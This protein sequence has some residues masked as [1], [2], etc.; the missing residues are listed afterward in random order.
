MIASILLAKDEYDYNFA[1]LVPPLAKLLDDPKTKIRFVATEALAVLAKRLG[2]EN[3]NDELQ[4]IVDGDALESLQKRFRFKAM[5]IIKDNYI[6]FPKTIP[7][8]A[9]LI[10]SPYL[11]TTNFSR[12]MNIGDSVEVSPRKIT[13]EPSANVFSASTNQLK[14][15]RLRPS[16]G[17]S[18]EP[19]PKIDEP[20]DNINIRKGFILNQ[21]K[22][23]NVKLDILN[24]N[25]QEQNSQ[26]SEVQL[27][28]RQELEKPPTGPVKLNYANRYIM[29][30]QRESPLKAI[31]PLH[32]RGSSQEPESFLGTQSSPVLATKMSSTFNPE[33][34]N[35]D[36]VY[37]KS[38]ELEPLDD[39]DIALKQCLA[40]GRSD[41]WNE[42][43]ETLNVLR[44]LLKHH[45]GVFLSQVTLHNIFLD[46]VK[47]AE[48][49][50]SALC[51]NG[52]ITLGEMAEHLGRSLDGEIPEFVKVMMKK[53]VDSNSF[54]TEVTDQTL[55]SMCMNLNENKLAY[56]LLNNTQNVRSPLVKSK[57][58]FCFG[59]IFEKLR[60]SIIR[61]RD[62]EK[63]IQLLGSYISDANP[64]VRSSAR[65]ALNIL[66]GI[67]PSEQEHDRLLASSLSDNV[68]KKVKENTKKRETQ[69]PYGKKILPKS[70][71]RTSMSN[72]ETLRV[73]SPRR[74]ELD[75]D[76]FDPENDEMLKLADG[77][78]N[79][80]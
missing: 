76:P 45:P 5:P 57:T 52:L 72:P 38:N 77:M 78:N 75:N 48:S 79:S 69:S 9:P 47:W 7:S 11:T 23:L 43:F 40:S 27:V 26:K 59:K 44:R 4:P 37:L 63:I 61:L 12:T 21:K 14:F 64:D 35:I 39:P 8:S 66:S 31:K 24:N 56:A 20:T 15:R 28:I 71:S 42:N 49:L 13:P 55:V 67:I 70:D 54:I 65:E 58:A 1:T 53:V 36:V 68:Y 51:K 74:L 6:E 25:K 10:S 73:H 50:R 34:A 32:R 80:E 46:V 19:L 30:Q 41:D 3:V 2:T 16:S 18:E 33:I 17:T 60:A 22:S 29:R 62:V